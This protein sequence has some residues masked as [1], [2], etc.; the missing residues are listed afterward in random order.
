MEIDKAMQF[1]GKEASIKGWLYNKRSSGSVRFLVVRDGTGIMQ[2]V[3][4]EKDTDPQTFELCDT[5]TQESSLEVSGTVRKDARAPG[6]YEL[7]GK[8]LKLIQLAQDYPISLKE[9]GIDF[10]LNHRHLWL[11]SRRPYATMRIRAEVIK[12]CRD[13]LD[14]EGFLLVDTPIFTPAACEGTTTLFEV[15]YFDT[16]VFLSQSGQLYNEPGAAAF[17]KVYCFGPTF[18]AEKSKTR[19]HLTEF[20]Q[21]EPEAAFMDL[22][23]VMKLIENLVVYMVERVLEKRGEELKILERDK[24]PLEQIQ[25]PFP[26]IHYN[27]ALE[28]LKKHNKPITWG[29]DFGGDEETVL[30]QAFDKPVFVHHFAA[31]CKPF[32][33]KRDPEDD[34]FA[35]G[36]DM[37]APEGYG[38]IVGGGERE[39]DLKTLEKRLTEHNLPREAFEWYLDLRR[40]GTFPHSGFGMG[41]ERTVAWLCKLT[42]L[43][44]AIPFPRLLDRTSP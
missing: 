34:R 8:S 19:R 43:R 12:A 39:N 33:M 22:D 23:G 15:D 20:W 32:Y 9:H 21:L 24:K 17:G 26:R 28:I 2:V 16:K 35:L 3:F 30:S 5:I 27:E 41:I 4:S 29:D 10:L 36:V 7:I 40:Y 18:R 25:A 38:E 37:L 1:E 31:Q 6:G 42:H 11:R 13:F 14:N 44:E